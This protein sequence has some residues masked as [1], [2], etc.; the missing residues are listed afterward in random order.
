MDNT[1]KAV[2]AGH[3]CLDITPVFGSTAIYHNIAEVLVPGKLV[4][5]KHANVHTGGA[6]ANTGMAMQ[7]FGVDVTMMG[8][9]GEDE[10]G[11]LISHILDSYE[12]KYYMKKVDENTSYSIIVAPPGID[13][14]FL[15]NSGT[16][17]T[18]SSIDLD[19]SII[20]EAALFHFGYPTLMKS[21]YENVGEELVQMFQKIKEMNILTSMDMAAIDEDSMAAS[22]D[23]NHILKRV[24]PYVDFFVPSFEELYFM[25]DRK[26]Y[27]IL[28]EKAENRDLLEL[29]SI[30][31]DVLPLADT[32]ITYGAKVVL[33]KCGKRG[34]FYQTAEQEVFE[35]SKNILGYSFEGWGKQT[36]LEQAFIPTRVLS[37]TGAG[38]T[39]IAAFLSSVLKG[40]SL[41]KA[42][43]MA[44]AAGALSVEE[45]DS[46]SG[47]K[48]FE[49]MEYKI[50]KGWKK[51]VS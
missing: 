38:D 24:L 11:E 10:F 23:W 41:S 5:M 48:T 20:E 26:K 2:V 44:S 47:L 15:H 28:L 51:N 37:A 14:I 13:R 29:I 30:E 34:I 31:E 50:E 33:I 8:K 3:I 42:L 1:K 36:G 45:Y 35:Q 12:C 32:L 21:M 25:L 40:Y 27:K 39:A 22:I 43:E 7:K 9:V 6:V 4:E 17:D 49:E 16:N 19:Y 46:F 18:F